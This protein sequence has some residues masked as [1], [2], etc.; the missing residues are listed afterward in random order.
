MLHNQK[1]LFDRIGLGFDKSAA[2]ST[3]FASS[4]KM[5]FLK[6]VT[7]EDS[8]AEKK[9]ISPQIF[10]GEKGKGTLFELY[11][12]SM[13]LVLSREV[14]IVR[15]QNLIRSRLSRQGNNPMISSSMFHRIVY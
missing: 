1:H 10:R 11:L 9:V 3:N 12:N 8:L 7:K 15:R 4:S 5:I 13:C 2:L 14:C 6:P